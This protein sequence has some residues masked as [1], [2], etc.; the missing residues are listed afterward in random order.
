MLF[1]KRL[2]EFIRPEAN[3]IFNTHSPMGIKYLTK[4]RLGFSHLK[5]HLKENLNITFKIQQITSAAVVLKQVERNPF[6]SIAL[7]LVYKEKKLFDKLT[8]LN[9]DVLT[10]NHDYIVKTL[11]LGQQD[12]DNA[13]NKILLETTIDFI[14]VT[15]R[16]DCPLL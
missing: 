5:E 1:E 14:I 9:I 3:S 7:T 16:F 11:L 6:F 13:T 12:F 8:E 2:L 4:L 10:R 15:E